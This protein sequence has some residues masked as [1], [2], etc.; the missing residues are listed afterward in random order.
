[1][2]DSSL[3]RLPPHPTGAYE[4]Q[5]SPG[6]LKELEGAHDRAVNQTLKAACT[7]SPCTGSGRGKTQLARSAHR[8][9]CTRSCSARRGFRSH[10]AVEPGRGAPSSSIPARRSGTSRLHGLFLPLE[11]LDPRLK[12]K[13]VKTMAD[14][15]RVLGGEQPFGG[16]FADMMVGYLYGRTRI[17]QDRRQRASACL[18]AAAPDRRGG[19]RPVTVAARF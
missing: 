12:P 14:V 6:S 17:F 16:R 11:D 10:A 9:P 7:P 13:S 2:L 19:A 4:F 8:R 1:V 18:A 5:V 15:D 3:R